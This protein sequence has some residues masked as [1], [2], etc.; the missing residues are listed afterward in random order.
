MKTILAIVT[1]TDRYENA[2]LKTSLWL[3]EL[4]HVYLAGG[5]GTM[6]DFLG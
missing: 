4:T 1:G 2:K 3:S 6:Y 5:H